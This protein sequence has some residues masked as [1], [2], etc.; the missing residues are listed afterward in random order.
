MYTFRTLILMRGIPGSGK[1]TIARSMAGIPNSESVSL[2][3]SYRSQHGTNGIILSTDFY[4]MEDGEY[5]FDPS[6]IGDNH[7]LNE[8]CCGMFMLEREPLIVIDNTNTQIWH[9]EPYVKMAKEHGYK[10]VIV[11]IPHPP[12][13]VAAERNSHGVPLAVLESMTEGWES[14]IPTDWSEHEVSTSTA[15]WDRR[16][17]GR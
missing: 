9:M 5:R 14:E 1:S 17:A 6:K 12:I 13:E 16:R 7:A 2:H 4:F 11:E 10:I 15:S 8:E 3:G